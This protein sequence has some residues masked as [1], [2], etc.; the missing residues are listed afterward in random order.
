MQN[1]TVLKK[2]VSVLLDRFQI[3]FSQINAQLED[4]TMENIFFPLSLC[5]SLM[6]NTV[7]DKK[8]NQFQLNF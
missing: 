1:L 3:L 8:N 4:A 7:A 6:Q 2:D 5:F